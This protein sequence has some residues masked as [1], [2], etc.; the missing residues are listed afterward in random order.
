[1]TDFVNLVRAD[2]RYLYASNDFRHGTVAM[3]LIIIKYNWQ[4][5]IVYGALPSLFSAR[6][7]YV[8][9]PRTKQYILQMHLL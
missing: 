4:P 7:A 2:G 5:F 1:M 6:G 9:R 3:I 8:L